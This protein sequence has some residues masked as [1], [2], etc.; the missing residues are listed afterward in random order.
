MCILSVS[1]SSCFSSSAPSLSHLPDEALTA[2]EQPECSIRT[3]GQTLCYSDLRR[4]SLCPIN[5]HPDIQVS[6]PLAGSLPFPESGMHWTKAWPR[7]MR[8]LVL[9]LSS[10]TA[11]FQ[12]SL[13][14]SRD[15]PAILCFR[16]S[17]QES[18]LPGALFSHLLHL[19]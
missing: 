7:W 18:P 6:L 2:S 14:R 11:L 10:V 9:S 12:P 1:E 8:Q 19:A 3:A 5:H 16:V 15:L 17:V 13:L 4:L